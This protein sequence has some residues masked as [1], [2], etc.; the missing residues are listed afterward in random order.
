MKVAAFLFFSC[1]VFQNIYGQQHC[2][3]ISYQAMYW[4][5]GSAFKKLVMVLSGS[6][7]AN[8]G[9]DAVSKWSGLDAGFAGFLLGLFGMSMVAKI[10]DTWRVFEIGP[11]AAEFVRSKLGLPPKKD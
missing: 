9:A 8:F 3:T 10:F 5:E 6:A 4:V 11:I 2:D 7:I 1:L